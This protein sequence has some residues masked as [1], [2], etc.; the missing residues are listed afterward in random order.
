MKP[1]NENKTR[2]SVGENNDLKQYEHKPCTQFDP[3]TFSKFHFESKFHRR[4]NNERNAAECRS[5]KIK[6]HTTTIQLELNVIII[7]VQRSVFLFS[8]HTHTIQSHSRLRK[9]RNTSN[10]F[11]TKCRLGFL[12][13][14]TWDII[15]C[16]FRKRRTNRLE[17]GRNS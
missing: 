2:K 9:K 4:R 10:G 7:S 6:P 14:F 17:F 3:I 13:L 11:D 8:I 15:S 16:S 1:R 12:L 5:K